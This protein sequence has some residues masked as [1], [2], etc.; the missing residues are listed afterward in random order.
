MLSCDP[1]TIGSVYPDLLLYHF[2]CQ[3]G[4]NLEEEVVPPGV[5][6]LRGTS[7]ALGYGVGGR[8]ARDPY[9]VIS[10][11]PSAQGSHL[12]HRGSQD[13]TS[14]PRLRHLE[15]KG[16]GADGGRGKGCVVPTLSQWGRPRA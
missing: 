1:G 6:S 4:E 5:S 14:G 13:S 7:S 3:G 16:S 2:H 11:A 10:Q 12:S 15:V 9:Q 8:M